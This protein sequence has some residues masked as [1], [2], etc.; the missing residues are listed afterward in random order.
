MVG[1][2]GLAKGI[3]GI[4]ITVFG[5][6]CMSEIS[7]NDPINHRKKL[8]DIVTQLEDVRLEIP[9]A[10]AQGFLFS[11]QRQITCYLRMSDEKPTKTY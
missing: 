9:D 7:E 2:E 4:M 8:Q 6:S 10:L 1:L 5:P 3:F 11:A